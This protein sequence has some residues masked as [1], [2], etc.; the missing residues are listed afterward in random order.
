MN[1]IEDLKKR[2]AELQEAK[3]KGNEIKKLK[4]QIKGEQ[5]AQ[6]GSGKVFNKIADVG[7]GLGKAI[8]GAGIK[9][10]SPQSPQKKKA[11]VPTMQ[12]IMDK[13]PQ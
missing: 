9:A 12:E 6:T 11:K 5:F 1:E 4:K 7:D 3:R 2:L 10:T 13:L 8:M